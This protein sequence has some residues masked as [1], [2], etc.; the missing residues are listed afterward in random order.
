L[1]GA[2]AR[3]A[4]SEARTTT[5]ALAL[6]A[7]DPAHGGGPGPDGGRA[8]D[9]PDFNAVGG[10]GL[11]VGDQDTHGVDTRSTGKSRA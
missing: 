5:T 7:G 6:V 4:G 2:A 1:V 10:L 8:L 3:S 11:G 9:A